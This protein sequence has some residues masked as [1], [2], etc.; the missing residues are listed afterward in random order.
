LQRQSRPSRILAD[1][2]FS[3]KQKQAILPKQ[4]IPDSP[5]KQRLVPGKMHFGDCINLQ[6]VLQINTRKTKQAS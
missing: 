4:K 2:P 5:T 3:G 1:E 6:H